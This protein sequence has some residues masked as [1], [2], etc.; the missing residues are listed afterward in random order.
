MKRWSAAAQAPAAPTITALTL[1]TASRS[2]TSSVAARLAWDEGHSRESVDEREARVWSCLVPRGG[3]FRHGD[4]HSPT[5]LSWTQV[6]LIRGQ[7]RAAP[8]HA[9]H[10]L[11]GPFA[12]FVRHHHV[13]LFSRVRCQ[14]GISM[15]D[16][17]TSVKPASTPVCSNKR[18]LVVN[19]LLPSS[20]IV[21]P[22]SVLV[23]P[24]PGCLLAASVDKSE[25]MLIGPSRRP[26][27]SH[28]SLL[29]AMGVSKSIVTLETISHLTGLGRALH[30]DSSTVFGAHQTCEMVDGRK[31]PEKRLPRGVLTI[32]FE[33]N[34]QKIVDHRVHK[35]AFAKFSAERHDRWI[36]TRIEIDNLSK[37]GHHPIG[38]LWNIVLR[39][40][41]HC[42]HHGN[43]LANNTSDIDHRALFI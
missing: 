15:T 6:V 42:S 24:L 36:L 9:L 13:H 35:A 14:A 22:Q 26:T 23:L 5:Q 29:P 21:C 12:V 20:W 4:G 1:S 40:A 7:Q 37:N 8:L 19:S 34:A 38:R 2:S 39:H 25:R 32:L 33:Q 43:V 31:V 17:L 27:K 16:V 3:D 18:W 10:E 30:N 11:L 28:T 41:Q